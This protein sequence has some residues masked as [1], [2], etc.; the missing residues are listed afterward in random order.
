MIRSILAVLGGYLTSTVL[1]L[2]TQAVIM[3]VFTEEM[4][5]SAGLYPATAF[6]LIVLFYSMVYA[7]AGGYVTAMIAKRAEVRHAFVLGAFMLTLGVL[8]VLFQVR[9]LPIWWHVI[10]LGQLIP[11]VLGGAYLRIRHQR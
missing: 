5:S 2:I 7:V 9:D 3:M 10:F 8:T 11:A 6:L 1:V 4:L